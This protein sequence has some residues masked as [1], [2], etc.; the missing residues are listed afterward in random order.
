MDQNILL[1][2][3]NIILLYSAL[4]F[5]ECKSFALHGLPFPESNTRRLVFFL[6]PIFTIVYCGYSFGSV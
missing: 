6:K 3:H 2:A 4:L 1:N 5:R